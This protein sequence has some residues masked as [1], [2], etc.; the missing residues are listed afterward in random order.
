MK[1]IKRKPTLRERRLRTPG[2]ENMT[3][4]QKKIVDRGGRV[5]PEEVPGGVISK[6]LRTLKEKITG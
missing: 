6:A 5:P 1:K 4:A 2:Y 3:P